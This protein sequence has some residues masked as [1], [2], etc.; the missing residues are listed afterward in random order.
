[1]AKSSSR[2][3]IPDS[4]RVNQPTLS[5]KMWMGSL[6]QRTAAL[7]EMRHADKKVPVYVVLPPPGTRGVISGSSRV[8]SSRRRCVIRCCDVEVRSGVTGLPLLPA[9]LW[10]G[11][12]HSLCSA[13]R[14]SRCP[15]VEDDLSAV[16][17]GDRSGAVSGGSRDENH[18]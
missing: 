5:K 11:C 7:A 12:C 13:E 18:E 14:D 3:R 4:F 1:M 17:W 2:I 6:Q 15:P 9:V 16:V 10:C 8:D